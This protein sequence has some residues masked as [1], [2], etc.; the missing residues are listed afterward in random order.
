MFD[1]PEVNDYF[2]AL[3]MDKSACTIRNYDLALRKFFDILHIENFEDIKKI[4]IVDCRKFQQTLIKQKINHST[5][6]CYTRNVKAFYGFLVNDGV[7][8][9]SPFVTLKM[10][11]QSNENLPPLTEEETDAMISACE[12]LE[13]KTILVMLLTLGLRVSELIHLR[14]EMIEGNKVTILG[15]GLKYRTLFMA[16]DVFELYQEYMISR[17]DPNF[18]YVFR[19]KMGTHY[20]DVAIRG[21]I[22]KI[23]RLAKIDPKRIDQI[24]CHTTRRT[25]ATNMVENG[26]DIR[27]IQGVLGHAS[28]VTSLKYANLRNSKVESAM[29]NQKSLLKK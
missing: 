12:K 17:K 29:I 6:N 23:A 15:K 25:C 26:T 28:L 13:E 16:P 21:K 2:D 5:A 1:I 27:V 10:L 4:S 20:S 3:K 14:V 18:E 11:K 8:E 9:K 22:K 19:S 7:I 24:S